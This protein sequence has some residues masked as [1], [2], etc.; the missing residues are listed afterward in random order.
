MRP[1]NEEQ[2]QQ[3]RSVLEN[4][5]TQLYHN[6]TLNVDMNVDNFFNYSSNEYENIT[7][8]ASELELPLY[9]IENV[10]AQNKRFQNLKSIAVDTISKSYIQNIANNQQSL[11]VRPQSDVVKMRNILFG[12]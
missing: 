2:K 10:K 7:R 6:T 12:K 11:I 5:R 1:Q 4:Y 9:Y 3:L 8:K